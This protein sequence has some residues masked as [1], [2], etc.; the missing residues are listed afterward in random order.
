M[1]LLELLVFDASKR[2]GL[3]PTSGEDVEGD[4]STDGKC[5]SVV[6]ELLLQN[7]D[8]CRSDFVFLVDGQWK[9]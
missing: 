1:D 8:E 6:S 2:V 7:L 5:Q 3:I 9:D 4:L